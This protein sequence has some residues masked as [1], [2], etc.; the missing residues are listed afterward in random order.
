MRYL[1]TQKRRGGYKETFIVRAAVVVCLI[2][3]VVQMVASGKPRRHQ[4][5]FASGSFP[6]AKIG[7]RAKISKDLQQQGVKQLV[8]VRYRPEH[9]LHD[10]WVYNGAKIDES[11]VVW[12]RELS[13]AQ[14][15][16]LLS[17]FKDRRVWLLD[18]DAADP[19]PVPYAAA[20]ESAS[21]R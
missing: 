15:K 2:M 13:P 14:D 19:T 9:D 8:I 21:K 17:Y 11:P 16:E 10:E 18:G 1:W 4:R 12:A 6:G 20:I 5:F 3:F 7:A